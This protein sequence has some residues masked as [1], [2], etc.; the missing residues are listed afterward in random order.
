MLTCR[1]DRVHRRAHLRTSLLHARQLLLCPFYKQETGTQ[2]SYSTCPGFASCQCKNGLEGTR[3]G[4]YQARHRQGPSSPSPE[5]PTETKP[6]QVGSTNP[7][8]QAWPL[9]NLMRTG[10]GTYASHGWW[11]GKA[12]AV[13]TGL[14]P[15]GVWQ[16]TVWKNRGD[17][18]HTWGFWRNG[19]RQLLQSK[20][21]LKILSKPL[22]GSNG[23][24]FP[25]FVL[26]KLKKVKQAGAKVK[27]N[28]WDRWTI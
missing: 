17:Y 11:P 22:F 16:L 19:P 10:C 12:R 6:E 20:S 5:E 21:L 15:D 18:P 4:G 23:P 3:G 27:T 25:G 28:V 7:T 14:L 8:S 9:G 26:S 24:D 2:R 13:V 1:E